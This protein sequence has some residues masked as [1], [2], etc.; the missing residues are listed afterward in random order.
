MAFYNENVKG[1]IASPAAAILTANSN[2]AFIVQ[3]I[4]LHNGSGSAVTDIKLYVYASGGL[5]TNATQV[6]EISSIADTESPFVPLKGLVL[7][8]GDVLA[9]VAGTNNAI[10]YVISYSRLTGNP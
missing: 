5:A 1:Q 2:E 4:A 7:K 6:Y 8:D 10:N 9:A 3:G